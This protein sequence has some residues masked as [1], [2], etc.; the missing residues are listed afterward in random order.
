M[1]WVLLTY[2]IIFGLIGAYL[3]LLWWRTRN[4]DEELTH[5]K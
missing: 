4:A 2:A 5:R 1:E 3:A